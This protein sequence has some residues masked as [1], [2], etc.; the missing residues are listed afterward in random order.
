M[1]YTDEARM[2]LSQVPGLRTY[3]AAATLARVADEMVAFALVLL[4]LERTGSP[5]LAGITGAAYAFPAV[6]TGP[7]L[8][9]WLDRTTHR[10]AALALNQAVLGTVMLAMLGVVGHTQAWATPALAVLAGASLPMVS[11]GFSSMLPS[12]V[13]G[14]MLGRANAIE[15]ASFGGATIT[16]PALAAT[17]AATVSVDAAV[18][19]IA[20]MAV[21]SILVIARLPALPPAGAATRERFLASVV[22]GLVHLVRTPPLRSSTVASTLAIGVSGVLLITLPLHVTALGAPRATSGYVWTAIEVGSVVTALLAGRLP[23]RHRPERTVLLSVAAYGL[24]M[25]TWP[26]AT[27]LA[28]LLVLALVAGL[29]EGAMMPAMLTARQVYSPL[30]LQGRV[31][32]TAASLRLGVMALGQAAGGLLVP[33]LGTHTALLATALALLA[34]AALGAL[35]ARPSQMSSYLSGTPSGQRPAGVSDS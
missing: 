10:R 16:G 22:G 33:H 4:V 25:L 23:S 13:P 12:L 20:V 3:C 28:V 21:V 9:A 19:T 29:L 24:A 31:S 6:L 30:A 8:G 18:A 34:A 15:A 35:A 14:P 27:T 5:A 7:L 26:L 2:R 17:L 11:G 32:T 1:R